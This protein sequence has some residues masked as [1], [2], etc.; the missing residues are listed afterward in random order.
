MKTKLFT[1]ALYTLSIF[2]ISSAQNKNNDCPPLYTRSVINNP[3]IN[4]TQVEI[5]D[6]SKYSSLPQFV[7]SEDS[8]SKRFMYP[9][10]AKRA[11]IEGDVIVRVKIDSNG[12]VTKA[13][14]VRGIGGGCDETALDVLL[15]T[16]F[17]PAKITVIEVASE[18]KI[19]VNF[20]LFIVVDKPDYLFDEI[21]YEIK[22]LGYYKKLRM[23]MN[24]RANVYEIIDQKIQPYKD[25]EI[26]AGLYTK[27][28]DF[29]VSQCFQN[30]KSNY[31]NDSSPHPM[32]ETITVKI[33]PTDKSVWSNRYGNEPVGLWAITNLILYVGD[34]V[35]WNEIK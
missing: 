9:E 17:S 14:I 31:S 29:I 24:N 22:G 28:S 11:G 20:S 33:G 21:V 27:L 32:Q 18:L 23:K 15:K 13:S 5:M 12:I 3:K 16:I 30:F 19:W 6:S 26:P 34:Q 10:I 2:S 25:G 7:L 8:L 1:I 4:I 35:K